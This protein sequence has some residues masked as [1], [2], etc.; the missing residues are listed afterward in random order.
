MGHSQVG[1]T[2]PCRVIE[3]E[4]FCQYHHSELLGFM[5]CHWAEVIPTSSLL[6]PRLSSGRLDVVQAMLNNGCNANFRTSKGWAALG[7]AADYGDEAL[8]S[9]LLSNGADV[10]SICR[11]KLPNVKTSHF[12][13]CS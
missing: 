2:F 11:D 6:T 5:V 12:Y 7:H 13:G 1:S 8:A 3:H 4:D 9:L 10:N